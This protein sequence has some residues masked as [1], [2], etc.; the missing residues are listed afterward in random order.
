[1]EIQPLQIIYQMINFGV[2]LGL[3]TYLLYKPILK[4]FDERAKRIEQGQKAAQELIEEKAAIEALKEKSQKKLETE[5]L[6]RLDQL[7]QEIKLK[8]Q[9]LLQ[10]AQTEVAEY[11]SDEE[12]KWQTEKQRRISSLKED[13]VNSII[14]TTEKV[15]DQKLTASDK[16]QLV[17][18]QLDLVLNQL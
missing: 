13:L 1:M 5:E 15:I 6:K 4:M 3:L 8:K 14:L 17:E 18:K 2:I 9:E 10:V 11:V 7:T 16:N 12:K